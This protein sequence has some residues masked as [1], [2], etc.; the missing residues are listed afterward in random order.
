M[1]TNENLNLKFRNTNLIGEIKSASVKNLRDGESYPLRKKKDTRKKGF[2]RCLFTSTK[3]KIQVVSKSGNKYYIVFRVDYEDM[4]RDND[5]KLDL[6]LYDIEDTKLKIEKQP[7]HHTCKYK[8]N[9]TWTYKVSNT[10]N[11]NGEAIPLLFEFVLNMSI[12][13]EIQVKGRI[14]TPKKALGVTVDNHT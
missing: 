13:Q 8:N 11:I 4:T 12:M 6:D 1:K 14:R 7:A 2:S 10:L 3:N 5:P 9:N